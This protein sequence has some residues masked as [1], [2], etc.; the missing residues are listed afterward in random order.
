MIGLPFAIWV[1]RSQQGGQFLPDYI[2]FLIFSS[3]VVGGIIG[4]VVYSVI[5]L[6]RK[7]DR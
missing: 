5:D 1:G 2:L 6:T 3:I 7:K 4:C